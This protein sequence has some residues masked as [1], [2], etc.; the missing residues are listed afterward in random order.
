MEAIVFTISFESFYSIISIAIYLFLT[1]YNIYNI[2]MLAIEHFYMLVPHYKGFSVNHLSLFQKCLMVSFVVFLYQWDQV[3]SVF[4]W[5]IRP[6]ACFSAICFE[7]DFLCFS[8]VFP[9][10]FGVLPQDQCLPLHCI[11]FLLLVWHGLGALQR[12]IIFILTKC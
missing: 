5:Y 11:I 7:F 10:K 4:C 9:D 2:F 12:V 3:Q 8:I 6:H 1:F